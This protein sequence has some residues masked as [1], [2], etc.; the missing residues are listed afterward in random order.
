MV[1]EDA[2]SRPIVTLLTD[3]GHAEPYVGVMKGVILSHAGNVQIVDLTHEVAPQSVVEAAFLLETAWAYFPSGTVHVAVVDPGVGTARKRIALR[4]AGHYFV[5]PD[6][7]V[8]S[9][10]LAALRPQRPFGE[11]YAARAVGLGPDVEAVAIEN[12]DV[13]RQPVSRT[14]EGRDVFAPVAA[15]LAGGVTLKA[16]GPPLREAQALPA[17]RAPAGAGGLDGRVLRA[18]RFGN[19]ITD[20]LGADVAPQT[21]FIAASQRLRLAPTYA[22]AAGLCA[23]IGSAGYVEIALPNGSAAAS[24]GLGAGDRVVAAG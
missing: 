2:L 19:L 17:F 16:L 24:L 8:L 9:A 1:S 23:V 7:G 4:F 18:D 14:F 10:A 15:H 13:L 21:L 20:I 11:G 22:A 12:P 6:N 5:G 3:F